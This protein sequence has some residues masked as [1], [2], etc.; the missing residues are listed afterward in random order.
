MKGKLLFTTLL[1]MLLPLG[2]MAT[3]LITD[4]AT[5]LKWL[6]DGND[7]AYDATNS[8]RYYIIIGQYSSQ[9]QIVTDPTT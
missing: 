9:S 1:T 4:P 8:S 7:V 2:I 3:T 6:D 5:G